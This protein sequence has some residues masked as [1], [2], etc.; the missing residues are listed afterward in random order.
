[1]IRKEA[2]KAEHRRRCT[3]S[4]QC[5]RSADGEYHTLPPGDGMHKGYGGQPDMGRR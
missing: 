4:A 3:L 1:L 5:Q 2:E